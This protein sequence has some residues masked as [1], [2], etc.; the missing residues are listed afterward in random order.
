M[1][2]L[3][4]LLKRHPQKIPQ[5]NQRNDAAKTTVIFIQGLT[6]GFLFFVRLDFK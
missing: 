3:G 2:K 1:K 5:K 6:G 4:G